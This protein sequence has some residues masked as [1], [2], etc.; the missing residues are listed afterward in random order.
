MVLTSSAH[1]LF[2]AVVASS[3]CSQMAPSPPKK[4]STT[5]KADKR[6]KMDSKLF[7][8]I[9]HFER[10]KDIFLKAGIIQERFIDL[11][12]LRQSFM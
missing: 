7:R 3:D 2:Y 6:L 8:S 1:I 4:K 10:Y 9:H 5:K 11:E 12:D